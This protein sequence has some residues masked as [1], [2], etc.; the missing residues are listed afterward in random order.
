MSAI[1]T[2]STFPITETQLHE[3]Y[4]KLSGSRQVYIEKAHDRLTVQIKRT[5]I[6]ICEL[7]KKEKEDHEIDFKEWSRVSR[8]KR[9]NGTSYDYTVIFVRSTQPPGVFSDKKP[10]IGFKI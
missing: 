6:T 3:H 10:V 8:L 7:Y 9:F 1:H 2:P 5:Q 4:T